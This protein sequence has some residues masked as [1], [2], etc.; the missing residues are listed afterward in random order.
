MDNEYGHRKMIVWKNLDLIEQ[1][2]LNEILVRIP[3][4]KFQLI[5]QIERSC[6]S[7]VANFVEGYYSGS[8]KEYMRFLRYSRRSLAELQDWVRRCFHKKYINKALY[9]K[10]DGLAIR[11]MYLSNRLIRSLENKIPA[12]PSKS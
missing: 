11:T 10:F 1:I 2:V 12:N 7:S 8:I 4:N 5:D 6:S 9:V 3:K